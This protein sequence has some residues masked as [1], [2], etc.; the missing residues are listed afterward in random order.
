MCCTNNRK[1]K[2]N[3]R[4]QVKLTGLIAQAINGMQGKIREILC[5]LLFAV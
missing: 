4:K 1:M 2:P 5:F 3:W